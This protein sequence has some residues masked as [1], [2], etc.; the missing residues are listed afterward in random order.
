[1]AGFLIGSARGNRPSPGRRVHEARI[2][3]A[4]AAIAA[5]LAG[6]CG[7]A[8]KTP[9]RS[10]NSPEARELFGGAPASDGSPGVPRREEA[11]TILIQAFRGESARADAAALL[12]S[13][14]SAGGLGEACAEQRGE[15][16][17]VAVGR[18]AGPDDRRAAADLE[19][20][21]SITVGAARPYAAAKLVP[22]VVH[23]AT[24]EYDL[25]NAKRLHGSWATYTLQVGVYSRE[26]GGSPRPQEIAEFRRFAED[27]AAKLRSG[28]EQA[29][30]Y[31]GPFRSMVTIGLFSADEF[32]ATTNPPTMS[33]RIRE[34]RE[35]FPYNLQNGRGIRRTVTFSTPSG[36]R[37]RMQRID[38][39]GLVAVPDPD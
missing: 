24:P 12:D 8:S 34:L 17:I 19:R 2:R 25:R 13:V 4:S 35:R 29:F 39:S 5:L 11:W 26:D 31:H 16:W 9:A 20:I 37:T 1:M 3:V 30:Y 14:R 10:L 6:G 15:T 21:R 32:D 22:P 27:A 33:P 7:S 38:P 18:Y 28:G 23:G 36:Q